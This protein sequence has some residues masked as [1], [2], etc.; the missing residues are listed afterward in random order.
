MAL[1][2]YAKSSK[3]SNANCIHLP[4]LVIPH[5]RDKYIIGQQV[6]R[7]SN[8]SLMMIATSG[9]P[10]A[11]FS[12]I[13]IKDIKPDMYTSDD[14]GL[15]WKFHGPMN[16]EWNLSGMMSGGGVNLLYLN[17]GR[18]AAVIHRAVPNMHGGGV[19]VISISSDEGETWGPVRKLIDTEDIYYVMNSRLRQLPSGR[20]ILPV[21]HLPQQLNR[22]KYIEGGICIA[23]CFY[24]DDLGES[25]HLSPESG[26]A[27]LSGDIRGMSEPAVE[28]LSNNKLFMLARTGCGCLCASYSDD[29][30]LHWS[31]PCETPLVSPCSSFALKKSS[32]GKLWVCY[33]HAKPLEPGSFFP[34]NPL[35]FSTSTDDGKTW[36]KPKKIDCYGMKSNT[37]NYRYVYPDI[38]FTGDKILVTY[39]LHLSYHQNSFDSSEPHDTDGGVKSAFIH[40]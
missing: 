18:L 17:D 15:N 38:C 36:S 25:W 13:V 33:N 3:I 34:R 14:N 8:G 35:V 26:S 40:Y 30:G 20:L 23:S 9:R 12:E 31:K 2:S 32:E 22:E 19:P 1:L 37:K 5:P 28:V 27:V 4:K 16:I 6:I 11:D 39:T 7:R 21:A 10:P 24:S 29:R